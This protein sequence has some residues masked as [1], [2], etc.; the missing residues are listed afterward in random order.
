MN[1]SSALLLGKLG[2]A[3]RGSHKGTLVTWEWSQATTPKAG[4]LLFGLTFK[5]PLEGLSTQ[6][7]RHAGTG[8]PNGFG[9]MSEIT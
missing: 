6:R 9:P 7:E 3:S 5:G 4:V 1:P 8:S 2:V